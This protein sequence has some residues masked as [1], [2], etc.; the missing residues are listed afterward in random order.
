MTGSVLATGGNGSYYSSE[1]G[2]GGSGGAI[3]LIANQISGNGNISALGGTGYNSSLGA[4]GKGRIRLEADVIDRTAGTDPPY[5]LGAPSSIFLPNPPTLSINTVA[6]TTVP[7]NAA[8]SYS[9]PDIM[10]ASSTTNPVAVEVG[11]TDIPVGTVVKVWILPRYGN[12][13]SFNATL[14]GSDQSST[15]TASVTISTVYANVITAEATFTVQQ[16]MLWNGEAI[17]KVRATAS[18]GH[19]SKTVYITSSGNKTGAAI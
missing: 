14:N 5:S 1:A 6:G 16:A 7:A 2:G 4:G 15:A 18:L 9:Q 11:A 17:E 12:A 8:G 3:K 10:L 13:T 19:G